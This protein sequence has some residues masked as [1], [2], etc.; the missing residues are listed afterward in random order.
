VLTGGE[1]REDADF[2]DFA[3]LT[4]KAARE[5]YGAGDEVQAVKKGWEEVG[6]PAS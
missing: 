5:R 1:L 2:A 6:V 3:R 4:V